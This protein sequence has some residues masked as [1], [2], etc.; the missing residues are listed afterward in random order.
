MTDT[1]P[2]ADAPSADRRD[3]HLPQF[4][5]ALLAPRYWGTWLALGLLRL[6]LWLPNGLVAVSAAVIGDLVFLL[7]A[8]RRRIARINLQLCFPTWPRIERRRLL[9]RHFRVATRTLL[10][11]GLLWWASPT[12]LARHIRVQGLEHY[13]AARAAGHNVIL[14]TGHF[15]ALEVGAAALS[16][17]Y[18]I[19]GLIKPVKNPLL[20]WVMTHGRKRFDPRGR[21]FARSRGMVSVVRAIRSG[22]GFYYLPDEDLG[23]ERCLMV[24]FFATV[25]ATLPTLG[26]LA[27]MGQAVV[28]P[29]ITRLRAD[30]RGYDVTLSAPLADFPSGDPE[31]DARRMNAQRETDILAAPE[32]YMWT[33]KLFKT[34]P[35]GEPSPYG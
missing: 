30:G 6:R 33:F 13:D 11:L 22:M 9:R 25:A 35:E 8:K 28:I 31:T 20:D 29:C 17:R 2:A 7:N 32:Q 14:L 3:H 21:L 4:R 15:V 12:Q 26:R 1:P 19:F 10:D 5:V 18:P 34:R 23:R 27:E 24:P 16:A